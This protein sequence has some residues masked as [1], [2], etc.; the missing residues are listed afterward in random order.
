MVPKT[1]ARTKELR[2]ETSLDFGSLTSRDLLK[3]RW[4][5]GFAEESEDRDQREQYWRI[6]GRKETTH[7]P[8]I[9]EQQIL[10]FGLTAGDS[11]NLR[12]LNCT[13]TR[14]DRWDSGAIHTGEQSSIDYGT[15]A[16]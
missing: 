4:Y 9:Q 10:S 13:V 15:K 8:V 14:R 2:C 1:E 11:N 3:E 12:A 6:D 5:P 16:L 7:S